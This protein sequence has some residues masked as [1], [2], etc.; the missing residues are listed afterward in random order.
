MR[1]LALLDKHLMASDF[2]GGGSVHVREVTKRLKEKFDIVYYPSSAV[3]NKSKDELIKQAK[4]L[5]GNGIRVHEGFYRVLE[6]SNRLRPSILSPHKLPQEV[7]RYYEPEADLLYEPDHTGFDVFFVGG[8]FPKY[9]FTMHVPIYYD[10]SLGYLARLIKFYGIN[11]YTLKGFH[12]RFLYNEFIA[13]RISKNLLKKFW[14]TFVLGVSKAPFL[15]SGLDGIVL[16]PGNAFDPEL[17]THRNRGKEDYMVFWSRLNQDKGIREVLEITRA[18]NRR[19]KAK[20]V[21]MG[22]FFDKYNESMFWRRVRDWGLEVEYLGFVERE[23]LH[24]VVSRAKVL[25]YPSHV[26]G[27]ALVVLEALA[28][29]TPVVAYDIPA[30][31]DVYGELKAMKI[32]KEF[33]V[34]GAAENAIGIMDMGENEVHDLMNEESMMNFLNLYS[35]WDRVASSIIRV[36]EQYI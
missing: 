22:K 36:I 10:Q 33:D 32:V 29:G 1:K 11:P 35:S 25:L 5:E 18:V 17:L 3:L 30:I 14:P 13:K 12:T 19:R 21:V 15:E 4:S 24:E 8:K 7:S 6:D 2:G 16:R 28:L 34:K 26:D 23:K 31:T 9:G 27:F 20:L